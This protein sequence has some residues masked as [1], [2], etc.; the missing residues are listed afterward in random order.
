MLVSVSIKRKGAIYSTYITNA[1]QEQ[2]ALTELSHDVMA[3]LGLF[4]AFL[5]KTLLAH[6][7][8]LALFKGDIE[9]LQ[10]Y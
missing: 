9:H 2:Q 4:S 5:A 6:F 3:N 10:L 7:L 1:E 8:E